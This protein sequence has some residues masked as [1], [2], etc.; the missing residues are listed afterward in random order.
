MGLP[1]NWNDSSTH[2]YARKGIERLFAD[3]LTGEKK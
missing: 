2:I 1:D 3:A